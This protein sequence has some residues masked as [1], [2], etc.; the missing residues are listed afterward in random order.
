MSGSKETVVAA[1]G[2]LLSGVSFGDAV[3]PSS[4]AEAQQMGYA[5]LNVSK[6]DALT[7]FNSATNASGAYHWSDQL[8]PHSSTNYYVPSNLI[9][10]CPKITKGVTEGNQTWEGGKL[11]IAG[12]FWN[13]C[14]NEVTID[15]LVIIGRDV[16]GK[17]QQKSFYYAGNPGVQRGKITFL[18]EETPAAVFH[19]ADNTIEIAAKLV[20]SADSVVRGVNRYSTSCLKFSGDCTEFLGT[21]RLSRC[22][23]E[24]EGHFPVD[25][26]TVHEFQLTCPT[27]NGTVAIEGNAQLEIVNDLTVAN[28]SMEDGSTLAFDLS[29]GS[30][31]LTIQEGFVQEGAVTIAADGFPQERDFTVAFDRTLIRFAEESEID[32][33]RFALSAK[34]GW[35]GCYEIK[36]KTSESGCRELHLVSPALVVHNSEAVTGGSSANSYYVSAFIHP[37]DTNGVPHW[38]DSDIPQEGKSYLVNDGK[39]LRLPNYGQSGSYEFPGNFL[40][41]NSGSLFSDSRSV[42]GTMTFADLRW[43]EGGATVYGTGRSAERCLGWSVRYL[44]VC[45]KLTTYAGGT[46]SPSCYNGYGLRFESEICGDGSFTLSTLKNASQASGPI[47]YYH[48]AGLNTNFTGKVKVTAPDSTKDYGDGLPTPGD[49]RCVSLLLSDGRNLGGRRK[50]FVYDALTLEQYARLVPTN[51]VTLAG[52]VNAGIFVNGIGRF[53]VTNAISLTVNRPITVNGTMRKEGTG[54]LALGA[55]MRFTDGAAGTL[56]TEGKNLVRIENGDL[57]VLAADALD[58]A[59]I[60]FSASARL[61]LPAFAADEDLRTYGLRN[62]KGEF[63]ASRIGL[64]DGATALRLKIDGTGL[65]RPAVPEYRI[66][67]VTLPTEAEAL[68]VAEK[69]SLGSNRPF[70]GFRVTVSPEPRENA[71]GTWTVVADIASTGLLMI[72][73]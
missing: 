12:T 62:V 16:R 28:L 11:V 69:L 65:E 54:T 27:F 1:L 58:G 49:Y 53:Y 23:E 70:P 26:D 22:S 48:L 51:D 7:P 29:K 10:H 40:Y 64:A 36:F 45:G 34:E 24:G 2:A 50:A 72:V 5:T 20:S 4:T 25:A 43:Y 52:D 21:L 73:R 14:K 63:A 32:E 56:P 35:N 3:Y 31:L 19:N 39:G 60:T 9:F 13:P 44:Y 67:L 55:A 6:S 66:G 18:G 57:R 61:V 46:I 41:I 17:A 42:I 47:G 15:D 33:S 68:A 37:F 30:T 59:A 38:S 71:D 8:A